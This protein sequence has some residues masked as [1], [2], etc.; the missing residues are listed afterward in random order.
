MGMIAWG[1][2]LLHPRKK[3]LA[4]DS[5]TEPLDLST[6]VGRVPKGTSTWLSQVPEGQEDRFLSQQIRIQSVTLSKKMS[7]VHYDP[8]HPQRE[9]DILLPGKDS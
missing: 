4:R 3:E 2:G 6:T 7:L 5:G 8:Q 1:A 9:L